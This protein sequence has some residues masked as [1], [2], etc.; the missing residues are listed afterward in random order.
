MNTVVKH[1]DCPV[2]TFQTVQTACSHVLR[3]PASGHHFVNKTF[4]GYNIL[5][6]SHLE[7]GGRGRKVKG[8]DDPRGEGDGSETK[9]YRRTIQKEGREKGGAEF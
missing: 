6:E 5:Q 4:I 9:E 2:I 1:E 8:E 3:R 7:G